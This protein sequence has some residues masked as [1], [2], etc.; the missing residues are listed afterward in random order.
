MWLKR[1]LW[2]G[3]SPLVICSTGL[4]SA[5][6][7]VKPEDH[8]HG[9][10]ITFPLIK[11]EKKIKRE[12]ERSFSKLLLLCAAPLC[13]ELRQLPLCIQLKTKSEKEN[14]RAGCSLPHSQLSNLTLT[15]LPACLPAWCWEGGTLPWVQGSAGGPPSSCS[16]LPTF[17]TSERGRG[18]IMQ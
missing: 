9:L 7:P 1:V 2:G 6:L 12:S 14:E 18:A 13:T 17:S 3:D 5:W 8:M 15:P 4:N 16:L 10:V 11:K